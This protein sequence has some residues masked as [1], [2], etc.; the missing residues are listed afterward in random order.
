DRIALAIV[1]DAERRGVLRPGDTL[2]EATA[3]NTGV[4]L[5]L[6]AGV[7]GYGLVCV[8]PRKMSEDKR[9]TLRAL[10]AEVVITPDAPP[11][12]PRNFQEVARRLARERGAF[13]TDQFETPVNP[14]IHEETTGPEILAAAGG[15]VAAFVAGAG[16]G[17]TLTGVG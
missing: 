12:D 1:L 13:L 4:G 3:G 17:G 10:G 11:G 6:V 5:A 15:R 14:R 9:A 2:I 7:R 16:T 8:M